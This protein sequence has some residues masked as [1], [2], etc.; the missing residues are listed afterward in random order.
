MLIKLIRR[1]NYTGFIKCE[2]ESYRSI[3]T[4]IFPPTSGTAYIYSL[5]IRK[6]MDT[7]RNS[8]GMCPQHNVLFDL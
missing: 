1:L 5:D 7:I 2:C 8:L 6:H 3:L 4:G